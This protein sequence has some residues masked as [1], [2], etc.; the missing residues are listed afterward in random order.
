MSPFLGAFLVAD[1]PLGSNQPFGN[2]NVG[3][4]MSARDKIGQGFLKAAV[5]SM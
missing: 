3:R 4:Y 5:Q 1:L 2:Q